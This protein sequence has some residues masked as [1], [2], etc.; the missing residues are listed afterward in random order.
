MKIK[1]VDATGVVGMVSGLD[2]RPCTLVRSSDDS[3]ERQ[4]GPI[5][6]SFPFLPIHPVPVSAIPFPPE[7]NC[8][9]AKTPCPAEFRTWFLSKVW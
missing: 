2:Y 9:I 5:L 7:P 1:G 6:K 4:R 3:F 8:G